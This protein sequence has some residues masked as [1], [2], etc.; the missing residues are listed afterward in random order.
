MAVNTNNTIIT[1][2][3]S[4]PEVSY[5][6]I[7]APTSTAG[8]TAGDV[9]YVTPLGTQADSANATAQYRFDGTK[10][11]KT[12]GGSAIDIKP[13]LAPVLDILTTP[14]STPNDQDSYIVLATAT[15]AWVGKEGDIAT[16]DAAN[17]VWE[18]KSP[19]D[20]DK[21]TVTT[22]ANAG[23]WQYSSSTDTWTQTTSGI[24][25]PIPDITIAAGNIKLSS[26]AMMQ[27]GHIAGSPMA[28]IQNRS[29]WAWG[30]DNTFNTGDN[31][32]QLSLPRQTS[33]S[34]HPLIDGTYVKAGSAYP[35]FVDFAYSNDNGVA[36]DY[37]GEVWAIGSAVS[38][39]GLTTTPTGT[40]AVSI[41]PI[42]AW[43]PVRF[44]QQLA[45]KAA[46][47][48]MSSYVSIGT[49]F[50]LIITQSGDGYVTGGNSSGQLGIGSTT[51]SPNW[52]KYPI[53]N[54]K[55]GILGSTWMVV[56]T[57]TGNVYFTGADNGGF[58]GSTGNKTSP[59]LVTSGAATYEKS[60]AVSNSQSATTIWVVKADN[61]LFAGGNNTNGQQGRGNTTA[62]TGCTQVTGITN[63]KLVYA[64][65]ATSTSVC[66]V[67]TNNSVSFAGLNRSGRHGYTL[68]ASAVDNTSFVTPTGAW[69]GFV[70]EVL[71]GHNS[72]VIR[73]ADGAVY[74]AGTLSNTGVGRNTTNWADQN[75]FKVLA[76]PNSVVG[77]RGYIENT[78][79]TDNYLVLTNLGSLYGFGGSNFTVRWT[80]SNSIGWSPVRIPFWGDTGVPTL[81]NL[82]LAAD[83]VGSISDVT[84]GSVT[85]I[86]DGSN[87]Q[88]ITFTVNYTG[89]SFGAINLAGSTVIGDDITQV[90][91]ST[92]SAVIAG[93]SGSFNV[94]FVIN[95]ADIA[96]LVPPN[97]QPQNY[98]LSLVVNGA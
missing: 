76:F 65:P 6:G 59:V 85:N 89:G 38:G 86:V 40:T 83:V 49:Q 50:S 92:T 78:A 91:L 25:V 79:N 35:E 56:V 22:G 37:S 16:W 1:G 63:A 80:N 82:P 68:N 45:D 18:F 4:N 94:S 58:T 15:G 27:T 53:G 43:H 26:Q 70:S 8:Y 29:I 5:Y 2:G 20:G 93:S 66:L 61:T 24:T 88:T 73:T 74:V 10:W 32:A 11:V 98:T 64:D 7:A 17:N 60:V 41:T 90:S 55:Y 57:A 33:V 46:K 48:Y 13:S 81:S 95:A 28:V 30:D 96:A 44:F 69:Q 36:I 75:Q 84:A 72:T 14:P 87:N 67:R 39:T 42:Y 34:Y 12:P 52:V 23:F 62:V 77:I 21:T 19:S 51:A 54:L 31:T 3:A 97:T 71:H 9:W 47:V